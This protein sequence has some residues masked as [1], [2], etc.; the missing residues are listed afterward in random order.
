MDGK[1]TSSGEQAER[2][3]EAARVIGADEADDALDRIMGKLDLKKKPEAPK[4]DGK[5]RE[6]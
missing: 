1:K 4:D 6:E 2:F 5:I 3:R